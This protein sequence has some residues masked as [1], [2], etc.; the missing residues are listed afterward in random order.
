VLDFPRADRCLPSLWQQTV[1][2]FVDAHR[3]ASASPCVVSL[4][5]EGLPESVGEELLRLGVAPMQGVP[6]CLDAVA[7]ARAIGAAQRS[8]A[9]IAPL[10]AAARYSVDLPV[11][12]DEWTGKQTLSQYGL[13]VP[14]GAVADA[15]SAPEIAAGL[16][17]PVVVKALSTAIAHKT[18]AGAVRVGLADERQVRDAV[19]AMGGLADRFLVEK[20]VD[21]VVAEL[22]VGV[23]RDPQFGLALTVGAGGVLVELM[24]DT[25]TLLLPT[26]RA[27]VREA[28][29]S[30]RIW[31]LLAGYR[32]R[33]A[34][35][36]D[37]V[38]DA[39]L[40]LAGYARVHQ[41]TLMELDVNPL[42]VRPDGAVA[43]DVLVRLGSSGD[44]RSFAS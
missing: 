24:R 29:R 19:A 6:D 35:D 36:V 25:V 23:H 14:T 7:A 17:F 41:D 40:A 3:G 9:E 30:L 1:D 28:L 2:A 31:P 20:Q 37:A 13:A 11:M 26:G 27:E 33:P 44:A 43:V 5:P 18:E 22:I 16:G 10:D 39:V 38:V 34:A 21:D 12:L 4:L 8:A 42:L 15:A 32:N